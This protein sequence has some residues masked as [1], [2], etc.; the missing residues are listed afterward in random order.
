MIMPKESTLNQYGFET[1]KRGYTQAHLD[2]GD[3][4]VELSKAG[5]L[6]SK[7]AL[8]IQT[9]MDRVAQIREATGYVITKEE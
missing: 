4:L 8:Y 9:E 5:A 3:L 6:N 7:T 1:L 2:L